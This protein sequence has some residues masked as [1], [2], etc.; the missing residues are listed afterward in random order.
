MDISIEEA[1]IEVYSHRFLCSILKKDEESSRIAYKLLKET[2]KNSK[3][4]LNVLDSIR[5]DY[6]KKI[7]KDFSNGVYT[8]SFGVDVLDFNRIECPLDKD[9]EN[10]YEL[11]SFII[12]NKIIE[13]SLGL[14]LVSWEYPTTYG[15]VDMLYNGNKVKVPCEVKL[16]TSDHSLITQI[17]K[18]I[19][20][21]LF[22]LHYKMWDY[23]QGI[24]IARNYSDFSLQE[25][26][27]LDVLILKYST[28]K[29]SFYLE[30]IN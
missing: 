11:K 14:K 12:E 1:V 8:R 29:D 28:N 21:F 18:Y 5:K 24:T 7:S 10:E 22:Y 17:E 2:A 23:V 13:K 19:H 20:H 9:F 16:N 25:L 26:R 27:K 15:R 30:K 6:L 3:E 4:S